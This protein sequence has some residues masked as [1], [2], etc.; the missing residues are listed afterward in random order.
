MVSLRGVGLGQGHCSRADGGLNFW[1]SGWRFRLS[2][3]INMKVNSKV[4][5][6]KAGFRLP[7]SGPASVCLCVCLSELCRRFLARPPRGWRLECWHNRCCLT[8]PIIISCTAVCPYPLFLLP[9]HILLHLLRL[10]LHLRFLQLV[11]DSA[12]PTNLYP[13]MWK[14][15]SFY[16]NLQLNL[17]KSWNSSKKYQIFSLPCVASHADSF[18]LVL[19]PLQYNGSEWHFICVARSIKKNIKK[20][21]NI[22]MCAES[23]F[24]GRHVSLHRSIKQAKKKKPFNYEA[25]WLMVEAQISRPNEQNL[26]KL[27]KLGRKNAPLLKCTRWGLQNKMKT[28]CRRDVT[29]TQQIR[30]SVSV[31]SCCHLSLIVCFYLQESTT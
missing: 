6:V 29:E 30:V 26:S 15:F 1:P 12:A 20:N 9:L 27:K 17:L 2:A 10:L 28:C 24:D 8:K 13:C 4:S 31:V 3:H 16:L 7:V 23:G 21:I 5:K 22:E 25:H 14:T 19:P 11:C 18:G